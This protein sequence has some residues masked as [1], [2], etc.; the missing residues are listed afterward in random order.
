MGATSRYWGRVF[1]RAWVESKWFNWTKSFAAVIAAIVG[2][3][4]G[5]AVTGVGAGIGAYLLVGLLE[6]VWNL[7]KIPAVLDRE[8]HAQLDGALA[9]IGDLEASRPRVAVSDQGPN[10]KVENEGAVATFEAR[11]EVLNEENWPQLRGAHFD[12]LWGKTRKGH[13]TIPQ[14]GQDYILLG[15]DPQNVTPGRLRLKFFSQSNQTPERI[16]AV[17]PASVTLR[18]TILTTPPALDAP[19]VREVELTAQGCRIISPAG[20]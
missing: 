9:R 1:Q 15:E 16:T 2:L 8:R 7:L 12:A 14:H 20:P 6:Y 17:L 3:V 5:D 19:I 11:L 10:L 18:V 4:Q 13:V